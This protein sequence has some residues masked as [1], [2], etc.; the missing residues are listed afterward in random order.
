MAWDKNRYYSRSV[1]VDGRIYREYIGG[2]ETGRLAAQHDQERREKIRLRRD[3][4]RRV[5]ADLKGIDETVTMLCR[6]ADLA[7]RAAMHTAGYYQHHRGEWRRRR[8]H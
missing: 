8:V 6:R 7:V 5:M 2:G 3:A 1:K 4:A